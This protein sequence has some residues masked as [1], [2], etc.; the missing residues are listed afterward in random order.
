MNLIESMSKIIIFP[1][2][3]PIAKRDNSEDMAIAE[4]T[5]LIDFF[6][7]ISGVA[8]WLISFIKR[9]GRS[10]TRSPESKY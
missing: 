4:T 1:S 3:E 8:N 2:D 6:S 7:T 5:L 10:T 9:D